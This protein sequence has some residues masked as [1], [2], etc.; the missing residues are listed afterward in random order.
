M[1]RAAILTTFLR[2]HTLW[3]GFVAV[4]VPLTVLLGFQFVWLARAQRMTALAHRAELGNYI[5]AIGTQVQYFYRSAAERTLNL[6]STYLT[7]ARLDAVALYWQRRPLPAA[8]RLFLVDFTHDVFG[9]FYVF[10][11][12]TGALESPPASDESLAM[13]VAASPWQMLRYSGSAAAPGISVDERNPEQRIVLNPILDS[14]S[15]VVGVAGMILDEKY[16]RKHLLP[17]LIADA[18]PSYFGA[19]APR[20]LVVSV[21]DQSGKQVLSTGQATGNAH[22]V[23]THLPFVFSDWSINLHGSRSTPEQLARASFVFNA[24]LSALLALTLVGGLVLALR[25]ANRA[26]RLSEMKSEFVSNVSH[27][28]RTPLSSIRTFSEL[29]RLGKVSRPEKVRE[30]GAYIE[31]ESR[32]LSR[33]IDNVLDF[34]R[35]ESGRKQYRF[36]AAD[37]V[38][39]VEATMSL[40]WVRLHES[41]FEVDYDFPAETLPAVV[42]DPDAIGQALHNL[43]DN[44]VKY[45]G[46]SRTLGVRVWRDGDCVA[47]AVQDHGVGIAPDEQHKVWERFH[48]VGTGLVHDVKGTGLGLAIVHHVVRAHGGEVKL[49][50][51]PGR[52]SKFTIRL[53]LEPRAEPA[54]VPA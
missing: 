48:R 25:S 16:F 9:N 13:I 35:I 6:P 53:P 22:K 42:M 20:D 47:I 11:P 15:H 18:L 51:A 27:E 30:Y 2:R 19:S 34:A 54:A 26:V 49:D 32:R 17:T 1:M 36:V 39:L 23:G 46:N 44:A 52:G 8:R 41:G 14:D 24:G 3:I 4:L 37:V 10:D 33:L 12:A 45:S 29:L 7:G 40:F 31:A 43:L 21:A 5:E 38:E 28:L 50:S